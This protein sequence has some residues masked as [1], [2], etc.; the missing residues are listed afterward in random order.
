MGPLMFYVFLSY[1]LSVYQSDCLSSSLSVTVSL[2]ECLSVSQSF[3][4]YTVCWAVCQ[5]SVCR[6]L[7]LS[8]HLNYSSVSPVCPSDCLAFCCFVSLSVCSDKDCNNVM[9]SSSLQRTYSTS[10]FA[11]WGWWVNT[12]THTHISS[13]SRRSCLRVFLLNWFTVA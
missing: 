11:L 7:S 6:T 8:A 3:S 2:A 10:F 5:L 13:S 9:K 4:Q 1:L 12:R